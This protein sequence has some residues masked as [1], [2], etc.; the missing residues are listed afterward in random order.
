VLIASSRG[1]DGAF[2]IHVL[3][4]ILRATKRGKLQESGQPRDARSRLLKSQ[5]WR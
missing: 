2:N 1:D 3:V 5:E 4:M